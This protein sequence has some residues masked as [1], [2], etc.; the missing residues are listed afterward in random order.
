M[1]GV[2]GLENDQ[3]AT[4]TSVV[5]PEKGNMVMDKDVKITIETIQ[6]QQGESNRM[7]H[8]YSGAYFKKGDHSY[9]LYEESVENT[10]AVIKSRLKF[11]ESFLEVVKKGA[12]SSTMYFE[13]G[14]EYLTEYGT[15]FGVVPLHIETRFYEMKQTADDRIFIEIRYNLSNEGGRI[16]DCHMKIVVEQVNIM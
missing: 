9:V 8:A 7:K 16:A 1:V 12:L 4:W 10:E 5:M 3:N 14:K 2:V 11:S 6:K 15:P 13:W